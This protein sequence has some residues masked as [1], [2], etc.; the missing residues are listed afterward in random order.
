MSAIDERTFRNV[1]GRFATGICVLSA[2][3]ADGFPIGMTVNSFSS[4]SLNPPLVLVCLSKEV[5]RAEVILGAPAF[6]LSILAGDHQE[7]S[8]HFA[9]HGMGEFPEGADFP[10]GV[11]GVPFMPGALAVLECTPEARLPGGD[12]DIL[13]GRVTTLSEGE[14]DDPLLYFAGGY[15]R[16]SRD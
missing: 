9:R 1:T 11:N 13:L 10:L 3:H 8:G 7:L 16:L 12:H 5:R 4:V 2:R 6:N 14:G 15:R